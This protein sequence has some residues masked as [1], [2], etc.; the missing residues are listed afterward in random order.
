MIFTMNLLSMHAS[1]HADY[2]VYVYYELR[3]TVILSCYGGGWRYSSVL[4]K[5][6]V[7]GPHPR[8]QDG[9]SKML[10]RGSRMWSMSRA[11]GSSR[12]T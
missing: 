12:R 9:H 6:E 3:S 8:C 5:R 1:H 2:H 4:N 10:F 11:G 7:G